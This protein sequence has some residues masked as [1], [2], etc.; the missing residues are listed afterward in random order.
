MLECGKKIYVK[1]RGEM[2]APSTERSYT[3]ELMALSEFSQSSSS[4][5]GQ[6][7]GVI[8]ADQAAAL[9]R[10]LF[11]ATRGNAVFE[12]EP[13]SQKLLDVD[14]K[15]ASEPVDKVFFMALFAGEV[16]RDKISKIA[17]YFGAT[18]Y[19]FPESPEELL[20]MAEEVER[21]LKESDEILAKGEVCISPDLPHLPI[22]PH[23]SP[24]PPRLPPPSLTLSPLLP[25]QAV[26]S[27]LLQSF[28][29]SFAT[30]YFVVQKERMIFDTL[31]MCEFD[32]KRHVFVAEGTHSAR[33]KPVSCCHRVSSL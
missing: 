8:K 20:T 22:S 4:L 26:L 10:V 1:S 27:E 30:Y 11:R 17:S 9:E 25:P 16:M 23:V 15:G 29:V 5:L 33:P 19:K 31:N 6:V 13:I 18:L 21:R 28:A 12:V 32:I 14:S 3:A 2:P 24:C 7:S